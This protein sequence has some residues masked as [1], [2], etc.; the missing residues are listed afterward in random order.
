LK[1]LFQ[2]S[3]VFAFCACALGCA[4]PQEAPP[5]TVIAVPGQAG[6]AAAG[7]AM[8]SIAIGRSS[9]ADVIAALGQTTAV[10][11]D[12]GFEVWVYRYRDAT[13]DKTG[14]LERMGFSGSRTGKSEGTELVVLFAPSGVVTKARI[15]LA[16]SPGEAL[17]ESGK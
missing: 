17:G 1:T 14:W 13:A 10:S 3:L 16:P 2:R 8:R 12:S 9:K 11:F 6:S 15:R 4:A 5:A 7:Y